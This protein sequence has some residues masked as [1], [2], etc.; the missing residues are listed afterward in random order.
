MFGPCYSVWFR[1]HLIKTIFINLQYG[2]IN[3]ETKTGV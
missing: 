3:S 2:N 1:L